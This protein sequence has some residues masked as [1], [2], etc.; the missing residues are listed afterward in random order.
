VE[1][2]MTINQ[3]NSQQESVTLFE[4][5]V[6]RL[7]AML[8]TKT[9]PFFISLICGALLAIARRRTVTQWLIAARISDDYRQAFYHIPH[10]GCKG[11]KIFDATIKIILE[12]LGPVPLM[13]TNAE[14][15]TIEILESYGVRFGIEEVFKDLKDVWGWGKQEVRLLESNEATTVM[16]MVLYTLTELATWNRTH[17]EL[18]DRSNSPWDTPNR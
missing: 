5:F 6:S 7:A 17:A 18:V 16:N 14:Q 9:R 2:I 4:S 10:I 3:T 12:Q 8:P 1:P 11:A 15:S 13:S